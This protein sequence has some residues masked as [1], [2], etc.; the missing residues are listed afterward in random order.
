FIDD[1]IG[2][3][4]RVSDFIDAFWRDR[5]IASWLSSKHIKIQVV[6]YSAT[7]Q[8]LRRLGFLKAFPEL[9]IYRDSATFITLPIKVE[10]RE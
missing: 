5:T 2:S 3:G 9:I 6:A 10:R 1:Y 8:G 7:A 4:Q